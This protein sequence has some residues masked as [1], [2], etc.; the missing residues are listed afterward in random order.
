MERELPLVEILGTAF[1]VDVGCDELRQKDR[2]D[3]RIPFN[4][5]DTDGDGYTFLY[6]KELQSAVLDKE[7]IA[8]LGTRYEWVTLPALL[9]LDAEG[10]ALKYDI[11]LDILLANLKKMDD[12]AGYEEEEDWEE[13]M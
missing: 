6:D 1:Y 3:N 5:F 11:P 9:E 8:Q 10:I 13:E 7:G 4:V 2:A 12:A